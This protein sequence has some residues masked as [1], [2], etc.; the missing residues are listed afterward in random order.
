MDSRPTKYGFNDAFVSMNV[1]PFRRCDLVIGTAIADHIDQAITG[2]V[3]H[4]PGDLI[5]M[6]FDNYF[7]FG[8]RVDNTYSRTIII[9]VMIVNVWFQI[10]QPKLL[11]LPF[12]TGWR[13]VVDIFFEEF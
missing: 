1:Y 8:F 10:L 11:T 7:V 9:Y 5:G 2:N 3:I 6:C 12:E 4:K 13:G